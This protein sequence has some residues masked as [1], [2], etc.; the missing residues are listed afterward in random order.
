MADLGGGCLVMAMILI[1][2]AVKMP[3]IAG[4]FIVMLA[5]CVGVIAGN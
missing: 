5:A 1:W 3:V 4:L 2:I